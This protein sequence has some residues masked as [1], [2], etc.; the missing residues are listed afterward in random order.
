MKELR[1]AIEITERM[2]EALAAEVTR[3]RDQRVLIRKLDGDG[4]TARARLRAE[5]NITLSTLEL[6]LGQQLAEV[7]QALS[8]REVTLERLK[9]RVPAEGTRLAEVLAQVRGLAGA[10]QELDSLNRL[11]TERALACVRG[12]VTALTVQ[13]AAYDRRGS[14][15]AAALSTASRV[16]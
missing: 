1:R 9:K 11:L 10:L 4:L 12:Y 8:M 5:F 6:E 15:T 16:I 3:A 2:R 14:A 13:P 7:A